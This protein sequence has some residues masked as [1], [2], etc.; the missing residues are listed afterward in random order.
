MSLMYGMDKDL[1]DKADAKYDP[2]L[3]RQVTGW[4]E[5]CIGEAKGDASFAEWLKDGKIL[6][7]LI[8]SIK[9][10]SVKKVNESTLAF[11]QMEN[12]KF[13]TDAARTVGVRESSMFGTPDL[14]EAKNLG[15]VVS[16]LYT[17][18]GAVQVTCP[19]FTGPKLGVVLTGASVTNPK[20]LVGLVTDQSGGYRSSLDVHRPK[21]NFQARQG[22]K[23]SRKGSKE[24][25]AGQQEADDRGTSCADEAATRAIIADALNSP[26]PSAW[27]AALDAGV[28]AGLETPELDELRKLIADEEAK[29]L[30]NRRMS[31]EII[32]ER[33][34][35]DRKISGYASLRPL[36]IE[37]GESLPFT[38]KGPGAYSVKGATEQHAISLG[39]RVLSRT[40][41]DDV[42]EM[43]PA[44]RRNFVLK[45]QLLKDLISGEKEFQRIHQNDIAAAQRDL[46]EL[47][48]L[49]LLRL[50]VKN[51]DSS[52]Q[53]GA[54]KTFMECLDTALFERLG[55][56]ATEAVELRPPASKEEHQNLGREAVLMVATAASIASVQHWSWWLRDDYRVY[57]DPCLFSWLLDF[58][59]GGCF[60]F[61]KYSRMDQGSL[62]MM[63]WQ[64][65]FVE[66]EAGLK[67]GQEMA[68]RKSKVLTLTKRDILRRRS[69]LKQTDACAIDT[70]AFRI[71]V[72]DDAEASSSESSEGE[73]QAEEIVRLE[74]LPFEERASSKTTG[75]LSK[76]RVW[77]MTGILEGR[78]LFCGLRLLRDKWNDVNVD[79]FLPSRA[80]VI[81][82]KRL[83]ED[84]LTGTIPL[85]RVHA[86]DLSA[87]M[88][89]L[90]E[91]SMVHLVRL[92]VATEDSDFVTGV[93]REFLSV[94]DDSL[95]EKL[96]QR[97]M[98]IDNT[99]PRIHRVNSDSGAVPLN[100]HPPMERMPSCA[101]PKRRVTVVASAEDDD[102][103]K[104]HSDPES[105]KAAGAKAGLHPP[106]QTR[107]RAAS[108]LDTP[109]RRATMK[110]VTMKLPD[111][112]GD[113]EAKQHRRVGREAVLIMAAAASI[114]NPGYWSLWCTDARRV[115]FCPDRFD[116]T[117]SFP[118]EGCLE[119]SD[120]S[121]SGG[122]A[123]ARTLDWSVKAVENECDLSTAEQ[124]A[125]KGA[126]AMSV[127]KEAI[128][129][130]RQ[131]LKKVTLSA[132]GQRLRSFSEGAM[133]NVT[134]GV[135]V[136]DDSD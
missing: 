133:L 39:L 129:N 15:A 77:C 131:S 65:S 130:R 71:D 70:S 22:S 51:E 47:S 28:A 33:R 121:K 126:R 55:Q 90:R 82:K 104:P 36:A 122:F 81:L 18:G 136:N 59:T 17:L 91:L 87:A 99:M 89:D 12:I 29:S 107:D 73:F 69:T 109:E 124:H 6:C 117:D 50:K 62:C 76:E 5:T 116:C 27:R 94:M 43:V 1:K 114:S 53:Q 105:P 75:A 32:K 92:R 23:E 45:E 46:R 34:R 96:G 24:T 3:E 74:A 113:D 49:P 56:R 106:A 10:G 79:M 108:A 125:R 112:Q 52:S 21:D 37:P 86:S 134:F 44:K 88:R 95:Y 8:N 40:W 93:H 98:G 102:E 57:F 120:Y 4:I 135:D 35:S 14:Y 2:E 111:E 13:F 64:V 54:H 110:R 132:P 42:V 58:P 115:F 9:P 16:T 80:N 118:D 67:T 103:T 63:D 66:G 72:K 20:R 48:L 61:G 85:H 11:K 60:E 7:K 25:G 38:K 19:E 101:K 41:K 100:E 26:S 123:V 78:A 128:L 84:I 119:I 68:R 30:A 97:A 31:Q 83:I 127:S